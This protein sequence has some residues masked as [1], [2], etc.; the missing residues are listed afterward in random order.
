[1]LTDE[2][3]ARIRAEE[4]FRLEI[5]DSVKKIPTRSE[6]I[7]GFF[8]SS[9]GNWILTSLLV[10]LISFTYNFIHDYYTQERERK[11]IIESIDAEMGS[12][13]FQYAS[14]VDNAI[15]M[16]KHKGNQSD[17]LDQFYA[18]GTSRLMQQFAQQGFF[19][20][21]LDYKIGRQQEFMA[22][23]N[24]EYAGRSMPSLI[25]ELIKNLADDTEIKQVKT[26]K[27]YVLTDG[28]FS[29]RESRAM[30]PD[31]MALADIKKNLLDSI[32][33]KRWTQGYKI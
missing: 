28:L 6:R 19:D 17:K 25:N 21:W 13:I 32:A 14:I 2:E 20:L 1:M 4:I 7:I 30:N 23:E 3:K 5:Q 26:V 29:S 31:T 12:R 8:N 10:G 9:L 16:K 18:L 22:I 24:P 11:H 15:R 33:I 27:K